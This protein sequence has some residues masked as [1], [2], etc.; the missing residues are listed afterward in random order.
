M[1]VPIFIMLSLTM[2]GCKKEPVVEIDLC[3]SPICLEYYEIWENLFKARNDMSD[4]YFDRHILI[5]ET[6]IDHWN[7]G[8]SFR[9]YYNVN[10]DWATATAGDK[11]IVNISSEAWLPPTLDVPKEEYLTEED[12]SSILDASGFFSRISEIASVT[13]LRFPSKKA[14]VK[15]L[16][17]IA[18]SNR[19]R[20]DRIYYKKSRH[21]FNANGHPYL[22]G[23][24]VISEISN[25]CVY[26]EIDL[27]TGEGEAGEG[28]CWYN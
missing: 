28:V 25:R 26:G 3:E 7:S 9:I 12:I 18:G 21:L 27:V 14:A 6:A 19:I 23:N 8:E 10:I 15:A 5:T 2:L 4:D 17:D 20:S 16:R 1:R 13:Q 24:G 22:V 11:F